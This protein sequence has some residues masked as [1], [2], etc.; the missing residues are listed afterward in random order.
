M[1]IL[2][3]GAHFHN[4]RHPQRSINHIRLSTDNK[5]ALI[6]HAM[7][8]GHPE[9]CLQFRNDN[10]TVGQ[11]KFSLRKVIMSCNKETLFYT[12]KTIAKVQFSKRCPHM[13]TCTDL[14]CAK[15]RP[16]SLVPELEIANNLKEL[17]KFRN[18]ILHRIM[19]RLWMFLR[20]YHEPQDEDIYEVFHCPTWTLGASFIHL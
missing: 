6:S 1:E 12:R 19:R 20:I 10:Y 3:S 14:K 8:D 16:D 5:Y 13:G 17:N 18:H 7:R 2:S 15:T 4:M 11:V 9:I